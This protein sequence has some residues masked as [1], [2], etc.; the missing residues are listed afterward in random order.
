MNLFLI[1]NINTYLPTQL[2]IIANKQNAA[3]LTAT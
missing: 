2:S 1:W 3:D